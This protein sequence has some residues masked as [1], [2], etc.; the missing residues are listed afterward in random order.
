MTRASSASSR[1]LLAAVALSGTLLPLNSTMLAVALPD[2]AD[3]VGGGV[4]ASTWLVTTYVLVMAALGPFA[5][6][7]GD[8]HGRRRMVL[9]GLGAFGA[10]S[11]AAGM[12]PSLPAAHRRARRPGGRRLA[13]DDERRRRPAHR[14]A[15]GAP[16]RRVR[17]VRLGG[18]RGRRDRPRGRRPAHRRLRLARDL[19]RQ[20]PG[21]PDRRGR[22]SLRSVPARDAGGERAGRRRAR[23]PGGARC[24]SRRSPRRRAR[25]G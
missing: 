8:R 13:R 6:R 12:A 18:R 7:L 16:R 17:A 9:L 2:I 25:R 21:R 20:R 19:P 5:G 23:A 15:G 10:A 24:A 14:A 4:A 3:G 1:S 22:S 11:A